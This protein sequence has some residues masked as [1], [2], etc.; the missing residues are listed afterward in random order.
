MHCHVAFSG[1]VAGVGKAYVLVVY[2]RAKMQ[3]G[4]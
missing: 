2:A 1:P 4:W 3:V